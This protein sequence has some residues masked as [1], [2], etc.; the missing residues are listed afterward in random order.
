MQSPADFRVEESQQEGSVVEMNP[1]S[2]FREPDPTV[3]INFCLVVFIV[4]G[5]VL[6]TPSLVARL[7]KTDQFKRIKEKIRPQLKYVSL[8][9]LSG[10]LLLLVC[11][12][13]AEGANK[14]LALIG[15]LM[16]VAGVFMFRWAGAKKPSPELGAQVVKSL[17]FVCLFVFLFL[18]RGMLISILSL[19]GDG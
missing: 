4:S 13:L 8:L 11:G 12:V 15:L 9:M 2:W 1:F 3:F 16:G 7:E 17:Y 6:H 14:V 18:Y 19:L 10:G 5:V